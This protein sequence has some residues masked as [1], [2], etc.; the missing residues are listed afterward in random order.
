M[1]E[2]RPR[3]L[4]IG[5]DID[6]TKLDFMS[7]FLDFSGQRLGR[8]FRYDE[9]LHYNV[10]KTFGFPREQAQE[11]FDAFY[12]E[13]FAGL[14]PMEGAV[15]GLRRLASISHIYDMT[16]RPELYRDVTVASVTKHFIDAGVPIKD[17]HFC[18]NHYE[19]NDKERKHQVGTRLKL[20]FMIEDSPENSIE[21]AEA[22]TQVL[23]LRR[24][25]N[26]YVKSR[27]NLTVCHGWDEVV[28]IIERAKIA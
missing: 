19:R 11:I 3:A 12:L 10:G 23:M 7:P 15:E 5:C 6:D 1:A 9:V 20:D 21:V 17:F 26:A 24:P 25:W 2:D 18:F 16:A 27:D 4:R 8:V 14:L 22:G 13:H 28:E